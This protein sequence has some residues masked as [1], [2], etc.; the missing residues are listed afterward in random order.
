MEFL[1]DFSVYQSWNFAWKVEMCG[2]LKSSKKIYFHPPKKTYFLNIFLK[3]GIFF[4]KLVFGDLKTGIYVDNLKFPHISTFH[5]KFQLRY[6][7]KFQR[8]S[9]FNVI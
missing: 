5:A 1:W 6:T 3:I 4:K 8:N 2:T 7:E 9:I